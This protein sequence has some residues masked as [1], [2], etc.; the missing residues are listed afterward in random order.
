MAYFLENA[1]DLYTRTQLLMEHRAAGYK[2]ELKD[3]DPNSYAQYKG[4]YFSNLT[5]KVLEIITPI[6]DKELGEGTWKIDSGNFFD[7]KVPYRIHTDTGL[8]D[9]SPWKTFVFPLK[10]FA[11]TDY[12]PSKNALYVL[13]QRWYGPA[14]FFV[15]G[16]TDVEEEYNKVVTDYRDVAELCTGF[17]EDLVADCSHLPRSNFEGL[18]VKQRFDWKPGNVLVFDRRHLHVASN[19]LRAGAHGKIGLS[20]FTSAIE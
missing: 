14:A 11:G 20:V 3:Y 17:D 6:I 4:R 9:V 2:E 12:D 19:F 7:T 5:P 13:N 15:K 8:P 1:V 18:T 16:S 10:V